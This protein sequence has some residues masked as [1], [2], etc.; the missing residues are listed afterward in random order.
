MVPSSPSPSLL[1]WA[2][3]LDALAPAWQPVGDSISWRRE[4]RPLTHSEV[5]ECR[6]DYSGS[7]RSRSRKEYD[8]DIVIEAGRVRKR[9]KKPSKLYR[10]EYGHTPL[11]LMRSSLGQAAD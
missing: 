10:D 5:T 11:S 3:Q 1:L 4:P 8:N 9:K 2:V 7:E 6:C